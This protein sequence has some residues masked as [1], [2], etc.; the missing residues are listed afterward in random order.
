MTDYFIQVGDYIN[1]RLSESA[2]QA[3]E[4]ELSKNEELKQAVENHDVM[5]GVLD[6]VWEDDAREVAEKARSTA[7]EIKF[8]VEPD[9]KGEA[10]V[11]PMRRLLTAAAGFVALM[12][13][14]IFLFQDKS[15]SQN[16]IL[17]S[18]QIQLGPQTEIRGSDGK[19]ETN[20][21]WNAHKQVEE[22]QYLKAIPILK[23]LSN[24]SQDVSKDK[25]Q[26]LLAFAYFA[27]NDKDDFEETI[28]EILKTPDHSFKAKAED[29]ARDAKDYYLRLE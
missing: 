20:S 3:F 23:K 18:H 12:I 22:G 8:D 29:F 27:N 1:G 24:T 25:A 7:E 2:K 14:G 5:E 10:K 28:D 4:D 6:M 16:D 19:D 21:L 9:L 11:I 15:I 26:Y 13:S 17:F